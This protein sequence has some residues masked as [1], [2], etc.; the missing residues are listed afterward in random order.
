MSRSSSRHNQHRQLTLE[1]TP[2]E[3]RVNTK[4]NFNVVEQKVDES[5]VIPVAQIVNLNF[6]SGYD[7]GDEPS[8]MDSEPS[9]N[10]ETISSIDQPDDK[11]E[12]SSESDHGVQ[13]KLEHVTNDCKV[14]QIS[15]DKSAPNL[16]SGTIYLLGGSHVIGNN[17]S[18]T[19]TSSNNSIGLKKH[20]RKKG[21]LNNDPNRV[22]E[23]KEE[24]ETESCESRRQ[25][26]QMLPEGEKGNK[27]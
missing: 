15:L 17:S 11:Q 23:H 2:A 6:T 26:M 27:Y 25:S 10:N 12:V 14:Q 18:T 13:K 24:S 4:Q 7:C 9:A 8:E 21:Q 1:K 5:P 20:K 22:E 19:D 16:V 3:L